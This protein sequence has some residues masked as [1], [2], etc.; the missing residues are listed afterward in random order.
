MTAELR[1]LARDPAAAPH[2]IVE[3]YRVLFPLGAAAAAAG[4]LLWTLSAAGWMPW[5]GPQHQTL[6]IEGFEH[7]FISGFL[8]TAMPAFTGGARCSAL[9]L[10]LSILSVVLSVACAL[11]SFPIGAHLAYLLGLIVVAQALARRVA[12]GRHKPPEEYLFLIPGFL[13]ALAGIALRIGMEAG[14]WNEPQPRFAIRLL[15][16]GFVLSLGLGIGSLLVPTFSGMPAPLEIPGLAAPH[17]RAPRRRLYVPLALALIAA[18]VLEAIGRAQAGALL[19]AAA[20]GVIV[21]WVWKLWRAKIL[22][23]VPAR[24]LWLSGWLLLAGLIVA[25]CGPAFRLAGEHVVFIGG[26]GCLTFGVATRVVASH[27]RH[28]LGIE[29]RLLGLP[30]AAGLAAAL[31]LRVAAEW[32]AGRAA[33]LLAASGLAWAFAWLLWGARAIRM[34]RTPTER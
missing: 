9:E 21:L 4:T 7:A 18:F 24:M 26:F 31:A 33:W 8:L 14:V 12:H 11:A 30:I 3:P 29:G 32:D 17:E 10:R 16:L 2:P 27:G 22:P 15:S 20:G 34:I 25:A 6:M 23:G 28:P 19:R 13:F 1:V 5:P